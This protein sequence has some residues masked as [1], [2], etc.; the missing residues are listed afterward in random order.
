VTFTVGQA[1]PWPAAPDGVAQVEE[2]CRVNVVLLYPRGA[3]LCRRRVRA[4]ELARLCEAAP[5]LPGVPENPFRR[6]IARRR[7][8]QFTS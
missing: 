7:S 6:G 8:K 1:V 3:R 2:L 4:V 5:L